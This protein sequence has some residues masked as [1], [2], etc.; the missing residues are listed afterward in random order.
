M[1]DGSGEEF[2]GHRLG[3]SGYRR[4]T[5]A[6]FLA[7][8]A[9]FARLYS[10][11]PILPTLAAEYDVTAAQ[12]AWTVSFATVGLGLALLV[13]GPAS[14]VLGRTPLM[15]ASLFASSVVALTCG[16]VH[17][18]PLLLGLRALEGVLLAGLPAVAMAYVA[19]EVHRED[20][21]KAAGLYVG[22]TALG[23][24]TGRLLTGFL[25]D[26][27]GWR[28]ALVGIGVVGLACAAGTFALLPRSR[29]FRPAPA[30]V[31]HLWRTTRELS[32]DPAMLCLFGIAFTAMGAFVGVFNVLGFRLEGPPYGLSVGV[33][34]LVFLTYALG[35]VSSAWAGRAVARWG[36]RRVEP[37]LVL[38]M[39]AG[40]LVT[41]ATPLWAVVV[42]VAVMTFGFFAVHGVASGWVASRASLGTG[43]KGQAG[44]LYLFSY[45]LGSSILGAVAGQAWTAAAWPGVVGLAA[46]LVAVTFVLALLLRRIPSL[47]EPPEPDPGV[48]AY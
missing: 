7:G 40:V 35:S 39:L 45:Y 21:S 9:T 2:E 19:D 18:W 47:E 29:R 34:G 46:V 3:S 8:L 41:A 10:T 42:G 24:M 48:V 11:Q 6:L 12:S 5:L 27:F 44:S 4:I 25:A 23:G 26:L 37:Y 14:E 22:G 17:S 16:L 31:A 28:L 36:H 1:N 38:M 32:T 30:S 13:A 20:T 15:F 43:A 33:A